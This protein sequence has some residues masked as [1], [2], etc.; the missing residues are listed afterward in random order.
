MCAG[1]SLTGTRPALQAALP[2]PGRGGGT[3]VRIRRIQFYNAGPRVNPAYPADAFIVIGGAVD[4][5]A[6]PG[7]AAASGRLAGRTRAG[8]ARRSSSRPDRAGEQ[9]LEVCDVAGRAVRT[10]ARGGFA[11]GRRRVTWDGTD[12][13]GRRVP[14]G[15]YP[16]VVTA[17][18]REARTR[19]PVVR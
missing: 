16:V 1:V 12:G 7:P 3:W 10:L 2:R 11:A 6:A 13:A 8:R 18:G 17:A 9:R 4:V 14:P 5:P 15:V 19:V